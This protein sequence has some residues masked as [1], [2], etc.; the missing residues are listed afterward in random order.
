M[1]EQEIIASIRSTGIACGFV[2]H[3]ND[4]THEGGAG[5]RVK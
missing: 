2:R 5:K 4:T 1:N 3:G